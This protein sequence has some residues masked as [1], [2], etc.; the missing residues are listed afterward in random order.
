M[1]KTYVPF[2]LLALKAPLGGGTALGELLPQA[3]RSE[4]EESARN[5]TSALRTDIDCLRGSESIVE[6]DTFGFEGSTGESSCM[7]PELRK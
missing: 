1:E 4:S 7:K 2:R 3:T 5:K 6:R